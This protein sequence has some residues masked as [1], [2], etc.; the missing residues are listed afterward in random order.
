VWEWCQDRYRGDFYATSPDADPVCKSAS[1]TE[2][3]LRG[4][5]W[6]LDARAQRVALRGGNLPT[7]KSQYVGLRLVR[8]L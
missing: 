8:E 4:G 1:A 2:H 6:F 7:F 5:C 3:V